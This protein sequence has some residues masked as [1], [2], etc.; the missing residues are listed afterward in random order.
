MLSEIA[1]D[2]YRIES[3]FGGRLLYLYLFCGERTTVLVDSGASVTPDEVIFPALESLKRVPDVLVVTHPDLDHQGGNARLHRAYPDMTLACGAGDRAQIADPRALVARRYAGFEHDHGVGFPT[4][5]K[6]RLVH[7]AGGDPVAVDRVFC[8]GERLALS[9]D[10]TIEILHLP[11]HSHGHLGIFDPRARIAIT[12]DAVH[13]RDYPFADG[14]PWALMPT[15]YY[16]EP[17][18]D[19]VERLRG[20]ELGALH[21]A[22]WPEADGAAVNERLDETRAYAL[23]ADRTV[24]DLIGQGTATVRELMDR[25]LPLLGKWDPSVAGDFACS[26]YGHVERLVDAGLVEAERRDGLMHYRAIREYEPPSER[27]ST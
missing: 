14:R 24:F 23:E 27:G 4:D 18:L 5:V 21:R 13:G 22:H 8:G 16:I 2:V 15:Y 19:T 1:Q 7:L 26:V 25:A 3:V 17:Y 9:D 20:L 10:W 11:G 6:P 12:Q